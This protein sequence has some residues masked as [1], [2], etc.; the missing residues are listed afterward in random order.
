VLVN[1]LLVDRQ[2]SYVACSRSRFQTSLY[3]NAS[4][5]AVLDD[6]HQK[7]E[8]PKPLDKSALLELLA[9]RMSISHAK[10]TSLDYEAK[11]KTGKQIEDTST[12]RSTGSGENRTVDIR[13]A[14]QTLQSKWTDAS[15]VVLQAVTILVKR[16]P[17]KPEKSIEASPQKRLDQ[18]LTP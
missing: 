11:K 6:T 16:R 17:A 14:V 3:V 2:W 15:R 10:G 13:E 8:D 7:N 9:K 1:P 12:S 4:A 18:E 5:L